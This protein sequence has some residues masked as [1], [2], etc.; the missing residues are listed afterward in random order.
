MRTV[1]ATLASQRDF[2]LDY[3]EIIDEA[4]FEVATDASEKRRAIVAGWVDGIR[5][6]DNMAM[7][8]ALVRA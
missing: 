7:Q 8:P 2:K 3:A 4:T 5:L 1:L 6:I